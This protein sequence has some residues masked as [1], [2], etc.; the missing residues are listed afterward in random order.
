MKKIFDLFNI[1]YIIIISTITLFLYVCELSTILETILSFSLCLY[2]YFFIHKENVKFNMLSLI[3]SILISV[4]FCLRN[5]IFDYSTY[6][7]LINY[8]SAVRYGVLLLMM[9]MSFPALYVAVSK[10]S[11]ISERFINDNNLPDAVLRIL[12]LSI[13]YRLVACTL[14]EYVLD[15]EFFR[16]ID[17][18]VLFYSTI[19]GFIYTINRVFKHKNSMAYYALLFMFVAINI[20]VFINA[21]FKN[22]SC[23]YDNRA[24]LFYLAYCIF[25]LFPLG[26][27]IGKNKKYED[28]SRFLRPIYYIWCVGMIFV[29]LKIF[30]KVEIPYMGGVWFSRV[31]WI[32]EHYNIVARQIVAFIFVGLYLLIYD[33][34]IAYYVLDISLLLLNYVVMI[35]CNSRGAFLA[36][37]ICIGLAIFF[38]ANEKLHN[39][40]ISAGL[41]L[42]VTVLF[43]IC[44][45]LPFVL[46]ETIT[47]RDSVMALPNNNYLNGN[48]EMI[49]YYQRNTEG[50]REMGDENGNTLNGRLEIWKYS[51]E[52][53]FKDP[54]T[55][56][57]GV[58]RDNTDDFVYI[59]SG[60][61]RADY[62]THNMLL[63]VIVGSGIF[64][65]VPYMIY[66][67]KVGIESLIAIV[68]SVPVQL[69]LMAVFVFFVFI[70]YFIEMSFITENALCNYLFF[71]ISGIMFVSIENIKKEEN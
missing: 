6:Y 64:A 33:R 69:K 32:N 36:A 13:V 70:S 63:E 55:F 21:L 19:I 51:I 18:F 60:G 62:H 27:W 45:D 3:I 47:I 14:F 28:I 16:T 34:K 40:Y 29:V 57:I 20:S 9:I 39:L 41:G 42:A 48:S 8:S 56:F 26:E 65:F 35:M 49:G 10:I 43:Y 1:E 71:L 54:W 23:F 15:I 7:L 68:K 67:C 5:I 17:S 59:A 31:L 25:I 30:Y 52:G 38:V 24:S 12:V 11:M 50:F 2:I 61:A 22:I 4:F 37:V 66:I 44:R 46:Y 53:L 58:T